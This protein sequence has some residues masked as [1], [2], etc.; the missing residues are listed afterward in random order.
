MLNQSSFDKL[1]PSETNLLGKARFAGILG[2]HEISLASISL[3]FE[4]IEH[5]C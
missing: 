3:R 5:L 4:A 2:M 1:K